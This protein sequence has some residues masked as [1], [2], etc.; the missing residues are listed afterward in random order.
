MVSIFNE[1][2]IVYI[3]NVEIS[4]KTL[5]R[6]VNAY[7]KDKKG[8][9]IICVINFSPETRPNYRVGAAE[10][11]YEIVLNSAQ[12]CYGGPEEKTSKKIKS[13]KIA[14]H[15]YNS[16]IELN[17]PSFGAIFLKKTKEKK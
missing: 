12:A 9:E 4:K 8:K 16:C 10:G 13:K 5:D 7:I 3:D 17:I 11:D 2:L 15:G 1:K 14:M 6:C